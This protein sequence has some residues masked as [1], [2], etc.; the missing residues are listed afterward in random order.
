MEVLNP[1]AAIIGAADVM[2]AWLALPMGS[3]RRIIRALWNVTVLPAGK[4][5]RFSPDQVQTLKGTAQS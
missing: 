4:G 3:K 1:A 2:G 5:I